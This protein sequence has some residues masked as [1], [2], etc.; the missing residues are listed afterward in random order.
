MLRLKLNHVSK[1]GPWCQGQQI[2]TW[3][4]TDHDPWLVETSLGHNEWPWWRH[5]METFSALLGP[6]SGESTGNQ[7]ILLAKPSYA[8]LWCFLWSASDQT[9]GQKNWG[10]S[11]LRRHHTHYFV[12]VMKMWFPMSLIKTSDTNSFSL[13]TRI[14]TIHIPRYM[15]CHNSCW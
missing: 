13:S 12:T 7:W 9:V 14:L 11:D 10:A 8:E 2:I 6:L 5:P 4:D 1:R 15:N 3:T